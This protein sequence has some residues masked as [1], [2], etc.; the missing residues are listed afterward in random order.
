MTLIEMLERN[1]KE[2]PSKI[3][4]ICEENH[5]T[6]EDLHRGVA[7]LSRYFL[8]SGIKKGDKIAIMMDSKTEELIVVFLSIVACGAVVLPVDCNQPDSY[9]R[10]LFS[11][12]PPAAVAI[13]ASMQDRIDTFDLLLSGSRIVVCQTGKSSLSGKS[14]KK[15]E[16]FREGPFSQEHLHKTDDKPTFLEDLFLFFGHLTLPDILINED[17]V[18]Y[19]NLTSGTTGFPKCAVTTHANIYWNTRSAVEQLSLTHDDVHLCMFPPGTHPHEIFARALL[20][21]GKMVLTDHIAPKSLTKVIENG[22]VTAMMAIAPIYG[23][24]TKCHKKN[25]FYFSTL[26]IVESGG[27]H[28]DPVTAREFQER[29]DLSITPVW[30]STETAGIALA[31]PFGVTSKTGSTGIPCRYYDAEIIDTHGNRLHPGEVG[32]MIVRGKG[33]CTSY[34]ANEIETKKNFKDGWYHTNDMFR[35][36]EDGFFYFAGRKNGMMKVAGMKVYPV[37]IEDILIQ[38]PLIKEISV[39]KFS[40][41]L[42]G[43][44]PKAVVVLEEDGALTKEEIRNYLSTRLVVYKIPKM[45]EF[46]RALPRNP[47]GKILINQI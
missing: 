4:V 15:V 32:E 29:F 38:H 12:M 8:H 36:D 44:I 41:P 5:Y 34:Y 37:E 22:G 30:G 25:G 1:F 17:D 28:L 18:V 19:F 39:T 9:C 23:N 45:I 16:N 11:L 20:L 7:A 14:P 6:Y 31:M 2:F 40:D 33:V 21:G 13:S 10:H 43:E 35:K 3:A 24:F 26:R 42:H 47:V 27:M 46:R